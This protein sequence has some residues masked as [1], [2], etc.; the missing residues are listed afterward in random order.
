MVV[1]TSPSCSLFENM[2]VFVSVSKGRVFE[3]KKE[4]ELE[5]AGEEKEGRLGSGKGAVEKEV[6]LGRG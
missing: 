2:F 3:G 5:E 1:Y 4:E 6:R